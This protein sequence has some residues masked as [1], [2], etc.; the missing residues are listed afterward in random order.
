MKQDARAWRSYVCLF[1][2]WLLACTTAPVTQSDLPTRPKVIGPTS[3]LGEVKHAPSRADLLGEGECVSQAD[4]GSDEVCVAIEPGLALCQAGKRDEAA[5]T[6]VPGRPV[7]PIGLL[8]G[9]MM[10][11]F[12]Q[13]SA[14]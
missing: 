7:P 12:A 5:S 6:A 4:C 9:K 8:D 13:R 14:Q 2:V 11:D 10:R 1:S 3:P